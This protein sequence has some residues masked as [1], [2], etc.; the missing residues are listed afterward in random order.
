MNVHYYKLYELLKDRYIMFGKWLYAKH[1]IFYNNLV[2][3]FVEFDIYDKEK[4]IFLSTNKRKKLLKNY[5]FIV[6]VLVLYNG[7]IND[8][9]CLI[10]YVDKSNFKTRSWKDDLRKLCNN[11]QLNYDITMKPTDNSDYMEGLYIKLEDE[12]K[13]INRCKYVR[14]YFY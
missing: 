10:N 13:V 9:E 8:L 2:H 4:S 5:N 6:S 1:T 14:E 3:Y 11:K 12:F 7:K